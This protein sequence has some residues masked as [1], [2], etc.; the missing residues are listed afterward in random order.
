MAIRT[1]IAIELADALHGELDRLQQRCIRELGNRTRGLKWVQP[2]TIHLT[3]RFLG[4]VDDNAITTV[5]S[6]ADQAAKASAPL[7]LAFDTLGT[8]PPQGPARVL[9]L[10]IAPP[11]EPLQGLYHHLEQALDTA[12]FPPESRAFHPHLTLARIKNSDTGRLV[13]RKRPTLKHPPITPCSAT[14][15]TVFQSI[16]ERSGPSYTPM[17]RAP[18]A[19][20]RP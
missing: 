13:S 5:C 17:H 12:G 10:G 3:L 11:H 20:T 4:D 19:E 16:L 2:H 15:L 18:L 1:F 9:W 14:R 6:A 7:E 8:F